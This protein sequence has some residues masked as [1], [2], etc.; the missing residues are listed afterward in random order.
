MHHER[1]STCSSPQ[2]RYNVSMKDIK[3]LPPRSSFLRYPHLLFLFSPPF[4][5]QSQSTALC[6]DDNNKRKF[7]KSS[8]DCLAKFYLTP[9]TI[10][11]KYF[12]I[13]Y[14]CIEINCRTQWLWLHNTTNIFWND[15]FNRPN[16]THSMPRS[17]KRQMPF[18]SF[19][20]AVT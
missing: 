5:E 8:S 7:V 18:H 4:S 9:I 2:W 1:Y 13:N 20:A 19:Q 6:E 17:N 12:R 11:M 10:K 14:D 3:V 15:Y 16:L